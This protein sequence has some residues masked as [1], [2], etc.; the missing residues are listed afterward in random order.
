MALSLFGRDPLFGALTEFRGFPDMSQMMRQADEG[1]RSLAIDVKENETG[2]TVDADLPGYDKDNVKVTV[3]D[4]VLSISAERKQEEETKT[5]KEWRRERYYGKVHRAVRL[6][7]TADESAVKADFTNGV[8][9]VVIGKKAIEDAAGAR[10]IA[11]GDG[12][13]A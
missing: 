1:F 6:P 12:S 2:F 13:S 4:G 3:H 10:H 7:D 9:K 11:I 8:L 5:D